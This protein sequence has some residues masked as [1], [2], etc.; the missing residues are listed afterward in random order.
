MDLDSIYK[1]QTF[2][3]AHECLE[4]SCMHH[5]D[6]ID[7]VDYEKSGKCLIIKDYRKDCGEYTP[8][9]FNIETVF[10]EGYV[11]EDCEHSFNE[12][13]LDDEPRG[14]GCRVIEDDLDVSECPEYF[15]FNKES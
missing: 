9:V 1:S 7:V 3:D 6:N 14:R 12:A 5:Q 4:T 8:P 15:V 10:D 13:H 2:C 11:C